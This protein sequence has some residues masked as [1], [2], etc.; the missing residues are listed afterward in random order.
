MGTDSLVEDRS[1][2]QM[3]DWMARA[4]FITLWDISNWENGAW[5]SWKSIEVPQNLAKEYADFLTSLGGKA[6]L[7]N[8]KLDSRG[9]GTS[10]GCYS[11]S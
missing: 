2:V 6:P 11:I 4:G 7:S 1:L 5:H 8:K 3:K 9:W 10:P